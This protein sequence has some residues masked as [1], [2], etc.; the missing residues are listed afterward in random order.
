MCPRM[1]QAPGRLEATSGDP[2]REAGPKRPAGVGKGGRV[3]LQRRWGA[4]AKGAPRE[5]SDTPFPVSL[6][7]QAPSSPKQTLRRNTQ[8]SPLRPPW[9]RDPDSVP[10]QLGGT[11]V[12]QALGTRPRGP[13]GTGA[14][15]HTSARAK[16]SSLSL[17]GHFV[18]QLGRRVTLGRGAL[19]SSVPDSSRISQVALITLNM[20]TFAGANILLLYLC[21]GKG[22]LSIV[23][24]LSS[25]K[26]MPFSYRIPSSPDTCP[27]TG[28]DQSLH[29]QR[30]P[31]DVLEQ[32]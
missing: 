28:A 26:Q 17:S 1:D 30:G 6:P 24:I 31:H 23:W 12:Q 25:G 21:F 8:L 7:T 14:W 13:Q 10:G 15:M 20:R 3:K 29:G 22:S 18:I 11:D 4:P 19:L 27:H 2:G 9:G 16:P 32:G 5:C